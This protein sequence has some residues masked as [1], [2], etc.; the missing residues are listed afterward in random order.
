MQA[1]PRYDAVALDVYDLLEGHVAAA[2]AAGLPRER[3]VVDP[4][5]GFGKTVAHNLALLRET[6]LFHGLGCGVLVGVSRKKASSAGCRAG[7]RQSGG[8]PAR[9][10]AALPPSTPAPRSC[11]FTTSRKPCRRWRCGGACATRRR[12]GC[13]P[14]AASRGRCR[15][16]SSSRLLER[17]RLQNGWIVVAGSGTTR[18]R[19]KRWSS[20]TL[21]LTAVLPHRPARSDV[22]LRPRAARSL[23]HHRRCIPRTLGGTPSFMTRH[24]F[25]HRRHSG[26]RQHRTDD[27]RDGS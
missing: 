1:A 23:A 12:G 7:S 27:R 14:A 4:G 8:C 26:H 11:A 16:N 18:N 17:S 6:A 20:T 22:R 10:P 2:E 21:R 25:R 19:P 5:I 13:R 9:S 15:F 24:L 3:I